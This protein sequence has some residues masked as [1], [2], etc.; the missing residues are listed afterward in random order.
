MNLKIA[1]LAGDGIGPEVILQAK[2]ALY[3][4][5]LVFDH[6]FVFE[7]AF[8]GAIAIDKTGNPLPEQTLNLCLNTDAVLFGAIG[9]PKYDNNPDA[10]VRP[11]QGLLKLRKSLGLFA[12]IRPIKP[13]ASLLNSSPLKKE[14]I[15]DADFIIFRELTGGVYF[16]E[17]KLNETGTI[18]SDLCEYSEEE[19]IRI[20]HL[21]FKSAQNRR[22]KV[23]MVDKANVLETSRLWRRVVK[24]VSEDYPDVALDFLFVDNAAMQIIL[25]PRQFDVILTENLFGD[26]LSDEASV[27]T[28]S[29]GLLASA[30][31]GKTNA[32]FEPIHG[33]YPQATGKN[34]ANPIASILSAA[35]LL[36]HFGLHKEAKKVYEAVE[37]AI[38]YNVVTVDLNA[39]S[40]FGTNEVGDFISNVILS[41]D[42]LY[43][44]I[45]NIKIGQSTIV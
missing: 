22:K 18:A 37:K 19:I 2:K 5:G 20:S 6:E 30:S 12:N 11:E 43:F 36:E 17:K 39:D 32:L 38:E 9:D 10:K 42:D 3:A 26:I 29:I 14:I 44:K 24:K 23:T 35:M 13:Y 1:A 41:K 45:D 28:G 15:Q 25:N 8:V 16:G 40:K 27:I 31:L 21:A 4:I 7:D 34:I 33:S